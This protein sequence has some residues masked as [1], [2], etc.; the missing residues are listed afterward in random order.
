VI[1]E[2]PGYRDTLAQLGMSIDERGR[3]RVLEPE[4]PVIPL[5]AVSECAVRIEL[6]LCGA[7]LREQHGP[8]G[9][10]HCP[11]CK[12]TKGWPHCRSHELIAALEKAS[13]VADTCTLWDWAWAIGYSWAPTKYVDEAC[14]FAGQ[15]AGVATGGAPRGGRVDDP[16]FAEPR[17]PE[18]VDGV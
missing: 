16:R 14:W 3:Y 9:R 6:L 12:R 17:A 8:G 18:T 4:R 5:G 15:Y 7:A 13:R 2:H 10:N 1:E 11:E